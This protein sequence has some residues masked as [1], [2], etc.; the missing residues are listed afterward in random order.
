MDAGHT[1]PW[2]GQIHGQRLA[3]RSHR[4]SPAE[5]QQGTWNYDPTYDPYTS[6]LPGG[7]DADTGRPIEV[8]GVG[9]RNGFTTASFTETSAFSPPGPPSPGVRNAYP[10]DEAGGVSRD[11][12]NNVRN[13]FDT[14]SWG[15]GAIDGLAPGD[16]VPGGVEVVFEIDL[17]PEVLAY[18]QERL[19]G[20]EV[21]LLVSGMFPAVQGGAA[22]FPRFQTR[23]GL[24]SAVGRL[25]LDV[26]V[27]PEP[28]TALLFASGLAALVARRSMR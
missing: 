28:G 18:L 22:T 16:L 13:A 3:Q 12:S 17:T 2:P 23:E 10:S 14:E 4:I 25:D 9:Y 26:Q 11:I 20:G 6:Y 19:D 7:V 21:D 8:S 24:A 1:D 27:V 5:G 15:I